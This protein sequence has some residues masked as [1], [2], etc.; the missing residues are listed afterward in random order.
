[1]HHRDDH[2]HLLRATYFGDAQE[3]PLKLY[4]LLRVKANVG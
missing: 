2:E 1:M 4:P 3:K